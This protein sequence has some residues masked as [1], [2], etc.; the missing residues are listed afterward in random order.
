VRR[1]GSS[2]PITNFCHGRISLTI[3]TGPSSPE[4]WSGVSALTIAAQTQLLRCF[5]GS[6]AS[7]AR[8][9]FQLFTMST[10]SV[11]P[12]GLTNP[13]MS[14][15]H[16]AGQSSR[17]RSRTTTAFREIPSRLCANPVHCRR[18]KTGDAK[19]AALLRCSSMTCHNGHAPL[20]ARCATL[21]AACG[22]LSPSGRLSRPG[23]ERF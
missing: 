18:G 11:L 9:L 22:R 10:S 15:R 3:F 5:T 19:M 14:M 23:L 17:R 16:G 6:A 2:G 7:P 8:R 12:T 1:S 13:E 20:L 4:D 21:R